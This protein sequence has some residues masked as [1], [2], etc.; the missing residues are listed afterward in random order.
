MREERAQA[1]V[2][3]AVVVP[4]LIVLALIVYNI[5]IFVSAVARFDRVVPDI[6]IAQ[7]ISVSASSNRD[8]ADAEAR[9][10]VKT[11]IEHAMDGYDVQIQVAS[12]AGKEDG[13]SMLALV[14]ATKTYVC[15]MRYSPWPS[16]LSIAGIDLGAPAIL[17]HER[18]VTVDPWRP[19]VLM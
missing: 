12:D 11:Q 15:T 4:V 16:R 3:M 14:G 8:S 18:R 10:A 2:E 7:G 9:K 17:S 5:M 6:A 19:G 13:D 1:T